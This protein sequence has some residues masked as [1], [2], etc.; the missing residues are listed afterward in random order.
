MGQAAAPPHGA[1]DAV[2]DT[3]ADLSHATMYMH[4]VSLATKTYKHAYIHTHRL[5]VHIHKH[6]DGMSCIFD[7]TGSVKQH[8]E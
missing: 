5:S 4:L 3:S 1:A 8:T 2:I 6:T 7:G